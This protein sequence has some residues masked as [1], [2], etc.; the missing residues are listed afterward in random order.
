M[1]ESVLVGWCKRMIG[2]SAF[3]P[4]RPPLPWASGK[5]HSATMGDVTPPTKTIAGYSQPVP[6]VVRRRSQ[7]I[8]AAKIRHSMRST[9]HLSHGEWVALWLML[10]PLGSLTVLTDSLDQWQQRSP[11]PT[12]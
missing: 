2:I 9:A 12:V 1:N 11:I 8:E 5:S 3:T 4:A 6:G 7:Y 10:T